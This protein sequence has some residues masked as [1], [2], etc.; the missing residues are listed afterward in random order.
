MNS[1]ETICVPTEKEVCL[2]E[3]DASQ[4]SENDLRTLRTHD[5]FMYHSIPAAH[6]AA[7]TLQEVNI[8]KTASTQGNCTVI[9]KS[10]ISTECCME[11][12]MEDF[13]DDEEFDA[14]FKALE[15]GSESSRRHCSN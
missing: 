8:S 1:F 7:L 15:I 2:R 13:F 12:L 3:I 6:K 4:L 10:Q 5:L 9:R 14:D 11:L